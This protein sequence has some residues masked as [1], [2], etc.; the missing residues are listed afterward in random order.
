MPSDWHNTVNQLY[1]N[2]KKRNT[3]C[4]IHGLYNIILKIESISNESLKMMVL[5]FTFYLFIFNINLIILI[6]G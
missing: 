5:F 1:F 6:G 4:K 3:M 2:F